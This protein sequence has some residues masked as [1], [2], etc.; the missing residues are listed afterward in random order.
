MRCGNT[1]FALATALMSLI[2]APAARAEMYRPCADDVAK[3]T[4]RSA[5]LKSIAAADQADRENKV[6]KPGAV[7]RDRLRRMRVGEIFGEGCMLNADDFYSGAIVYQHGDRP[8]HFFQTYVWANRALE[9][10]KE[11]ARTWAALGIDRYLVNS[12]KKQLFATQFAKPDL[13]PETCYC[14]EQTEEAFPDDRRKVITGRSYSDSLSYLNELNKGLKCKSKQC[15]KPLAN[16][17]AG[18][19]PGVW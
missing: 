19:L 7:E 6:L 17:P 18:S 1:A 15:D 9:L 11:E 13:K 8:E 4:Q 14:I 5:E 2:L 3:H 16:N 12:G 10:G